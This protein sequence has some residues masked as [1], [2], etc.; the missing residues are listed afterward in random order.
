MVCSEL[1]LAQ[2]HV[3]LVSGHTCRASRGAGEVPGVPIHG[4]ARR[5]N[6][7]MKP[8]GRTWEVSPKQLDSYSPNSFAERGPQVLDRND[9]GP[10]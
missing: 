6:I 5:T 2:L 1:F 8:R 3:L 4:T 7:S 10:R 9:P